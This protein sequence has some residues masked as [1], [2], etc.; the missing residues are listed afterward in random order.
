MDT[1]SSFVVFSALSAEI[2][3]VLPIP[4]KPRI[5]D[6]IVLESRL[7]VF[8]VARPAR[9]FRTALALLKKLP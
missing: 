8:A 3:A 5:A 7:S 9:R 6:V 1:L 4:I 2:F